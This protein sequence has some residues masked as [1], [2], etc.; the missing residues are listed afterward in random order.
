MA[1]ATCARRGRDRAAAVRGEVDRDG[2]AVDLDQQRLAVG[3]RVHVADADVVAVERRVLRRE[4]EV[5]VRAGERGRQRRGGQV[6]DTAT[7]RAVLLPATTMRKRVWFARADFSTVVSTRSLFEPESAVVSDAGLLIPPTLR[8]P[9]E[10]MR[11][12][13]LI[14]PREM[15]AIHRSVQPGTT[16]AARRRLSQQFRL[17]FERRSL[18]DPAD[19]ADALLL[20][21]LDD[22]AVRGQ[23]DLDGH[24]HRAAALDALRPGSR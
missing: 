6:P 9:S 4:D 19:S 24:S 20:V 18:S 16:T 11:R 8:R 12:L 17:H 10:R 13:V 2:L 3:G 7:E 1:A 23:R 15:E 5:V 14:E 22:V 21:L